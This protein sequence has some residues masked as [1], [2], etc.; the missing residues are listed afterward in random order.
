ML[1]Q[2]KNVVKKAKLNINI[3]EEVE[4]QLSQYMQYINEDDKSY[5][6][7]EALKLVFK[8]DKGF[9][10]WKKLNKESAASEN[11]N[12]DGEEKEDAN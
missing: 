7:E 5:I 2:K 4:T 6:V 11:K 3:S 9:N 1:I 8:K 10:A 12:I